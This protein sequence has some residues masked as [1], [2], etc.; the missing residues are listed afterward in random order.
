MQLDYELRNGLEEWVG[1]TYRITHDFYRLT[2]YTD[3]MQKK[4]WDYF[5]KMVPLNC[6][7]KLSEEDFNEIH[8]RLN[9]W[10]RFY[11]GLAG[12]YGSYRVKSFTLD[13]FYGNQDAVATDDE[14]SYEYEWV[15]L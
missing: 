12:I 14:L 4:L 13:T 7:I 9:H 11:R 2:I 3:K 10:E 8:Y 5:G 1:G 6:V 15:D